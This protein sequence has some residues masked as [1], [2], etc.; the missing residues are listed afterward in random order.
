MILRHSHGIQI[1]FKY[2]WYQYDQYTACHDYRFFKNCIKINIAEREIIYQTDLQLSARGKL[3]LEYFCDKLGV[4]SLFSHEL[5]LFEEIYQMITA[6][7][8]IDIITQ[9]L[10]P[11]CRGY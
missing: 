1:G 5:C 9:Y 6:Q 3:K 2:I 11:I 7:K 4:Y 8:L 10:R